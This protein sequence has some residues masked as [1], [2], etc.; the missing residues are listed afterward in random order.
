M[1][2]LAGMPVL[3]ALVAE[4]LFRKERRYWRVSALVLSLLLMMATLGL[5]GSRSALL[6]AVP[7][8]LIVAWFSRKRAVQ[9]S[10]RVDRRIV[11]A[12]IGAIGLLAIVVATGAGVD[13]P[14]LHRSSDLVRDPLG[15]FQLRA[16]IWDASLRLLPDVSWYGSGMGVYWLLFPRVQDADDQ[17]RGFNSH[18]DYLQLLIEGGV[19]AVLLLA[20]I[21]ILSGMAMVRLWR[22]GQ[23]PS[24][25]AVTAAGLFAGLVAFWMQS[26]L[27]SNLYLL[28]MSFLVGLML[29]R[30][31][32]FAR[33][34][35]ARYGSGSRFRIAGTPL[36]QG[37][38][39]ISAFC[40]PALL[41]TSVAAYYYDRGMGAY[42]RNDLRGADDALDTARRI[43]PVFDTV[44]IA[45]ADLN[46]KRLF[47]S[48]AGNDGERAALIEKTGKIL[49]EAQRMNPLRPDVYLLR[50]HMHLIDTRID[51]NKQAFAAMAEYT[52]A[53]A[54]DPRF[55]EARVA[56]S[57]IL[58][59]TGD[60]AG[61]HK[62]LEQ[63]MAYAY[64]DSPELLQY[65]RLTAQVRK[66]S[67]DTEGSLQLAARANAIEQRIAGRR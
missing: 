40:L 44:Q 57:I 12:A 34:A 21:I 11:V 61:A 47:S 26:T 14:L 23:T 8:V 43:A 6:A 45:Q 60:N 49:D 55:S 39:V 32:D 65:L 2:V 53:L 46:V 67:G 58:A 25:P 22:S 16:K 33:V 17:S 38:V 9:E 3:A 48:A 18:N 42:E 5:S 62:L 24:A 15:T 41:I 1:N 28:P 20:A 31:H 50:G 66:Q 54:L 27:Q 37:F 30:F 63:G 59:R 19:P 35:R 4:T 52:K 10:K 64:V 7:G 36:F 29:G 56:M 51:A 13:F